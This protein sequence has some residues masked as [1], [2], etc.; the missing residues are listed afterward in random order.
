M[1][2]NHFSREHLFRM[3]A[4]NKWPRRIYLSAQKVVWD[5]SEVLA[6]LDRLAAERAER[7][8]RRHD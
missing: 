5:L 2:L 4:A 3:E 8:Y 1:G 6:H 7:V